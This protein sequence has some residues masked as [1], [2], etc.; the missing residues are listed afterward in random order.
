MRN[1]KKNT[2]VGGGKIFRKQ[3]NEKIYVTH[4]SYCNLRVLLSLFVS[5]KADVNL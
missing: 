5:R 1:K 2:A 3:K 4:Y